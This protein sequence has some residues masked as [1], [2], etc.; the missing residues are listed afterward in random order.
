MSNIRVEK[1][2]DERVGVYTPYNQDFVKKIKN[3]G[4]AKWNGKCWSIP[5]VSLDAVRIIMKNI[6]G[7]D[8]LIS[9]DA[10]K[11]KVI[12]SENIE[13]YHGDINL[14]GK[15]LCHAYGRDSGG[16]AGEDVAYIEGS[17]LSSGSVRNWNSMIPAGSVIILNNVSKTLFNSY[18]PVEGIEIQLLP[19]ELDRKK[20]V[21]EKA[22]L[23][24]RIEEID[25][26]L[27]DKQE[28]LL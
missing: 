19:Q 15:C 22:R 28:E 9:S 16:K 14:L 23:L 21:E 24:K 18:E 27:S 17:P 20:L 3:I 6:Y 11:V 4:G 12:V 1:I 25:L 2:N 7:E 8:D 5:S 26:L 10:V 13:Q